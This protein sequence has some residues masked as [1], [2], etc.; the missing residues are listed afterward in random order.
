V[1]T[2]RYALNPYIKQI[3]FVFKGLNIEKRRRPGFQSQAIH[4]WRGGTGTGL[5]PVLRVSPVR[6][7]P[8]VPHTPIS[9]T[10]DSAPYSYFIHYRHCTIL[11][12]DT[13]P[14]QWPRGLRR[15]SA[16]ARLLG[17]RVR[18]QPGDMNVRL[19]WLLYIFRDRFLR[20]AEHSFRGVLT[21]VVRLNE[22]DRAALLM[23]RPWPTRGCC[24]IA[25]MT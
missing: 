15:E 11:N 1:F 24:D 14:T 23:R 5:L 13:M 7:T 20:G 21:S 17:L 12:N 4:M 19:L 16:A 10:T 18:I 22:C 2:A 6:V 25:E 3:R 9:F 8:P